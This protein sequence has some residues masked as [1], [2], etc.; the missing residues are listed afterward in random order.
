MAKYLQL[1][2]LCG[3]TTYISQDYI[4]QR[5]KQQTKLK[6]IKSE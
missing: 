6:Q 5:K 2:I 1:K 3:E 4:T